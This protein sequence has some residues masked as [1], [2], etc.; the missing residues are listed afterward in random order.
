MQIIYGGTSKTSRHRKITVAAHRSKAIRTYL[1]EKRVERMF[2]PLQPPDL[3]PIENVWGYLKACYRKLPKFAK[4]EDELFEMISD[5]WNNLPQSY[6]Q[7]LMKSMSI[8]ASAVLY[9]EGQ[10][11]KY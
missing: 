8:R 9:R 3:N 1:D 2:W 11:T 6:F 7:T 4:N 5:M 10:S